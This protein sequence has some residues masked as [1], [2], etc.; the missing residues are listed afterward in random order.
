MSNK[1]RESEESHNSEDGAKKTKKKGGSWLASKSVGRS[2]GTKLLNG[3]DSQVAATPE[4]PK[5]SLYRGSLRDTVEGESAV[6]SVEGLK[7]PDDIQVYNREFVGAYD[8]LFTTLVPFLADSLDLLNLLDPIPQAPIKYRLA[9]FVAQLSS[10]SEKY[11][12]SNYIFKS[13]APLIDKVR[14][15]QAF[16]SPE[17]IVNGSRLLGLLQTLIAKH[18]DIS[19]PSNDVE[20]GPESSFVALS[21]L[22]VNLYHLFASQ[23]VTKSSGSRHYNDSLS[24]LI[25]GEFLK[26]TDVKFLMGCNAFCL[27]G[28]EVEVLRKFYETFRIS[29]LNEIQSL[30][31]MFRTI[32]SNP[33][34]IGS[35]ED[36]DEYNLYFLIEIIP[37]VQQL[38]HR[39]IEKVEVCYLLAEAVRKRFSD[40]TVIEDKRNVNRAVKENFDKNLERLQRFFAVHQQKYAH[41]T[42]INN[43]KR[44]PELGGNDR[45]DLLG[46]RFTQMKESLLNPLELDEIDVWMKTIN[47]IISRAP[48]KC[49]N[50][51]LKKLMLIHEV[52]NEL[53]RIAR[54]S[55][56]LF[57]KLMDQVQ[58]TII[59][60]VQL[61]EVVLFDVKVALVVTKG[62]DDV[63]FSIK[64]EQTH[65]VLE[66]D[67]VYQFVKI[68]SGQN[69]VDLVCEFSLMSQ[70]T[71]KPVMITIDSVQPL[72]ITNAK[73]SAK[74]SKSLEI[75]DND[76][77]IILSMENAESLSVFKK[78]TQKIQFSNVRVSLRGTTEISAEELKNYMASVRPNL[79]CTYLR[80]M[81]VLGGAQD[82]GKKSPRIIRV[83]SGSLSG[84]SSQP[85]SKHVLTPRR[86]E[87]D[88]KESP[89]VT[90]REELRTSKDPNAER[91]KSGAFFSKT[92]SLVDNR[93]RAGSSP[94]NKSPSATNSP[95]DDQAGDRKSRGSYVEMLPDGSVRI[96]SPKGQGTGTGVD[97]PKDGPS[98][99]HLSR[100]GFDR[101]QLGSPGALKRRVHAP[102][103]HAAKAPE[104]DTFAADD[105]LNF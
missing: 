69:S 103:T 41:L 1:S 3:Q 96:E 39:C 30:S 27:P 18:A 38:I 68:P 44:N 105:T 5:L 77:S 64:E 94:R 91:P 63:N 17:D 40:H 20:I 97:S 92:P 88:V 22:T 6:N 100:R 74:P 60:R 76:K 45:K 72:N 99:S 23:I 28:I 85:T 75:S 55:K 21:A 80:L 67:G 50:T 11:I 46:Q 104:E 32:K 81:G 78:G 16:L 14:E 65:R 86:R 90:P 35:F 36:I 62:E 12:G 54:D 56:V 102:V 10:N 7:K 66:N 26:E 29:F 61:S 19:P 79:N 57:T 83:S 95:R 37:I 43:R 59:F 15:R 89:N 13:F 51:S 2:S 58:D 31:P 47:M 25:V 73:S 24:K 93:A 53:S 34:S 101:R 4:V 71:D 87:S 70:D 49:A 48:I 8:A 82:T 52:L 33:A 84:L 42:E 9:D 98:S